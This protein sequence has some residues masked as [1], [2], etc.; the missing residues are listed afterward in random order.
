MFLMVP[1]GSLGSHFLWPKTGQLSNFR[2]FLRRIYE[3]TIR[4]MNGKLLPQKSL[5]AA[6]DGMTASSKQAAD[7]HH[8]CIISGQEEGF[9]VCC[10]NPFLPIRYNQE[11]RSQQSTHPTVESYSHDG[12][13]RKEF[14]KSKQ[15]RRYV[16]WHGI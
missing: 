14:L 9:V 1:S 5:R 10:T 4:R 15:S 11:K 16:V 13:R 6:N 7:P 2:I 12:R 3:A 8:S